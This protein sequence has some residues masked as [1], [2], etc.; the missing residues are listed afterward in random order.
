MRRERERRDKKERK[1]RRE[2]EEREREKRTLTGRL[3]Y[4]TPV[5]VNFASWDF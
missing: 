1:K 2:R 5:S 3:P 4:K